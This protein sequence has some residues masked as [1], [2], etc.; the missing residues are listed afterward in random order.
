MGKGEKAKSGIKKF[1]S[2][3]NILLLLINQKLSATPKS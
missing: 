2:I 3:K 1:F